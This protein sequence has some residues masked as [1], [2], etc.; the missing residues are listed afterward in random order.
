MGPIVVCGASYLS[1]SS[2][3]PWAGNHFSEL[4]AKE[5]GRELIV[6]SHAGISNFSISLQ[7]EYALKLSPRPS[8]ILAGNTRWDRIDFPIETSSNKD[9][10]V[11]IDGQLYPAEDHVSY[12]RT[13]NPWFI[14]TSLTDFFQP[15]T[16]KK[17]LERLPQ[18]N[19][20]ILA[21]QSYFEYLYD[22][23]IKKQIDLNIIYSYYH[24]IHNSGIPYFI[25]YE[26]FTV[27][28]INN[29][30]W[31]VDNLGR[32]FPHY[33]SP[34]L[35][36][37]LNT[38]HDGRSPYHTTVEAQKQAAEIILKIYYENFNNG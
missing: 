8:L 30:N 11:I 2:I 21:A 10:S 14:S 22:Y 7:V 27:K 34:Q 25:C 38:A 28:G 16:V 37:L 31:L 5:L 23:N 13:E 26:D 12:H 15:I 4:I 29:F 36:P 19:S 3:E 9:R 1:P 33:V 32:P 18:L 17:W 6:L 24:K 35:V 20:K